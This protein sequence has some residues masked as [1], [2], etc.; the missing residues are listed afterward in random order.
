MINL[1]TYYDVVLEVQNRIV[2]GIPANPELV[3]HWIAAN[4]PAVDE[5]ERTK[6]ELATIDQLPKLTDEAAQATYTT[7]KQDEAGI[8]IEDR[9]VKA[10]FKECSNIL[11]DM[12]IAA[13]P[14]GT[15]KS[16]F[17][18]LRSKI[19]E[20]IFLDAPKVRFLRDGQIVTKAD[21]FE[22]RPIHVM[23]AQ[24]PRTALKRFDFVNA[25]A[26]IKFRLK[27]LNKGVVDEEL[28]RTLL[29]YGGV[30]GLGADR[31][32]EVGKFTV[33]S[34]AKVTP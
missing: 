5:A 11:R 4:M 21:G 6:L 2:G 14:P 19:A 17:V 10:M 31:A 25:P 24:G 27:V 7:F 9:N 16:K 8:Y 20:Q 33:T 18:N 15:K 22:E 26:T 29:E 34:V 1:F 13:E 12:L 28:I 3:K 23:T 30:N 32:Q